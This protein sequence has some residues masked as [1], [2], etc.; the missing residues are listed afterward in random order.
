M[1]L[2]PPKESSAGFEGLPPKELNPELMK[3]RADLN[4]VGRLIGEAILKQESLGRPLNVLFTGPPASKKSTLVAITRHLM[5][6]SGLKV[7]KVKDGRPSEIGYTNMQSEYSG[8]RKGTHVVVYET[9]TQ[10][11]KNM[12]EI[13][14]YVELSGDP[15]RRALRLADKTGS[16]E[17]AQIAVSGPQKAQRSPVR[18]PDIVVNTDSITIQM[19]Q[20]GLVTRFI[21]EG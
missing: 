21:Q 16:Y 13:D 2:H 9:T 20:D 12:D 18:Q 11:P 3:L 8:P 4:E 7:E 17:F 10:L 6:S 15:A 5:E 19:E 14:V 1:A